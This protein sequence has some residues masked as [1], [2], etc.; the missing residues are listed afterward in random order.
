[1]PFARRPWRLS[2]RARLR[3]D[4]ERLAVAD[5]Q[6][7]L[8]SSADSVRLRFPGDHAWAV[9]LEGKSELRPWLESYVAIGLRIVVDEAVASGYPWRRTIAIRGRADLITPA[10]DTAHANRYV[11]WA[12]SAWGKFTDFEVY[13]DTQRTA[14]LDGYLKAL[15][16]S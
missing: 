1:L 8:R 10:G 13:E 2:T 16:G 4:L 11:V 15:N 9:E 14:A 3:R 12:R 5:Y 6:P 7:L